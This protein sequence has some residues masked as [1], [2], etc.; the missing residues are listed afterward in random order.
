M[1][2]RRTNSEIFA[3]PLVEDQALQRFFNSLMQATTL[4]RKETVTFDPASVA[5]NITARQ[6][7]TVPNVDTKD[8]VLVQ[9]PTNTAGLSVNSMCTVT[10]ANTVDVEFINVT[11]AGIDAGSEDY[12]FTII[13]V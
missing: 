4:I 9:K 8:V 2:E 11:A 1:A 5:A 6:S 12:V 3:P 13:K 10:A 7:V